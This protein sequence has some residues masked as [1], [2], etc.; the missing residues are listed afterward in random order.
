MMMKLLVL[1]VA[2]SMVLS[3]PKIDGLS[4]SSGDRIEQE[5]TAIIKEMQDAELMK[6][7][8]LIVKNL[9]DDQLEELENILEKNL[10]EVTEFDMIMKELKEMGMEDGDI[11]D[12]KELSLMMYEFL[13][14][15]PKL[16]KKLDFDTEL[17]LMD[18][19]QLYLL[20]LSNKLGPLG[21]IALHHVLE[22][23]ATADDAEPIAVSAPVT[24]VEKAVELKPT[25]VPS[26]RRKRSSPLQV[27]R[28][29]RSSE[30]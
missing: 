9:S 6:E 13:S 3:K 23:E 4:L 21:Y 7:L 22:E 16:G 25:E 24:I 12:L 29:R 20:G 2:F 8:E 18:N 5:K 26:F 10:D 14:Q 19:I 27:I 28:A 15:V 30:E 17:D 11:A 1:S